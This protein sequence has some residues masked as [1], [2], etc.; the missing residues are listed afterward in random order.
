MLG[1]PRL[2]GT[3]HVNMALA[4][5]FLQSYLFN[6]S[7]TSLALLAV[8][9]PGWPS[10]IPDRAFAPAFRLSRVA[11][12]AAGPLLPRDGRTSAP[13][14]PG[15]RRDASDDVFLFQQ[16]PA[17]GLGRVAFHDW[18]QSFAAYTHLPNVRL[19]LEQV[20][21]FQ[22]LLGTAPLS[23]EQMRDLD[24]LLVVGDIFTTVPYA[25]LILQQATL[26]P[27][28]DDLL[29]SIFEVL[30]RDVSAHALALSNKP[31]ATG[32]QQKAAQAIVRRP[33]Y[34]TGRF[35]RVWAAARGTAGSYAMN[36]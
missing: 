2:E 11:I 16:G 7:D 29:D 19:F 36:P 24:L 34:D 14:I 1:L 32:A 5:K 13:G 30:V 3:V 31:S 6:P 25:D 33:S 10:R 8:R 17:S 12:R 28:E 9:K 27:V 23:K 22:A 4:L 26:R 15:R 20:D 18:R 21:A 35:E